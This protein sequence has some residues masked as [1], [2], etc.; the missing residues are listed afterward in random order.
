MKVEWV[1]DPRGLE[2]VARAWDAHAELPFDRSA[3]FR[4][5]WRAFGGAGRLA[6]ATAWDGGTLAGA[7]PVWRDGAALRALANDHTPVFRPLGAARPVLEAVL[8]RAPVATF[9]ALTD[10]AA[11]TDELRDVARAQSRLVLVQE[12]QAHAIVE[13][14]EPYDAYL[15]SLDRK[16]RK[17]LQ[18]RARRA[19]DELGWRVRVLEQPDDD[20]LTLG[21]RTEASGWK[22]RAGS[23][24]LD[25]P[26]AETFYR[27]L[28][29]ELAPAVRIS[30]LEHDGRFVAFDLSVVGGNRLWILKGG[31]D[32]EHRRFAPGLVLTL[33]QIEAAHAEGYDAV[34]LLGQ[35]VPWKLRFANTTRR[36]VFVGAYRRSPGALS[37]Y[38]LR[39]M[40]PLARSAYR[41]LP[42]VRVR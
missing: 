40:R 33:A 19:A 41:R 39:R 28:A 36:Q 9:P 2:E 7:L 42:G 14:R 3:W 30:A 18:R 29:R 1:D 27:E 6:V 17:D 31:F 35:A 12:Y 13:T 22:G 23:S 10:R 4:A 20:A 16:F 11:T 15:A 32:E 24:I 21:F 25:E 38:A 37:Q 34:E 8:G 5:W 26:G